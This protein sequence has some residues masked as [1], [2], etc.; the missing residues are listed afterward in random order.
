M[1]GA[2]GG[3]QRWGPKRLVVGRAR[4]I[5]LAP[6]P[7][8]TNR[9]LGTTALSSADSA[10]VIVVA[11]DGRSDVGCWGGLLTIEASRRGVAGVVVHGALRDVDEV[12]RLVV[13][14][15]ARDATPRSARGRIHE[16]ATDVPVTIDGLHVEPG[17]W[18]VADGSGVVF[19]SAQE[20]GRVVALAEE[21]VEEERLMCKALRDGAP[22]FQVLGERYERLLDATDRE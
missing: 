21:I 12:N 6:G 17:A 9:H 13:P 7:G 4:T 22:G 14:V 16:V 2:V 11:S 18:V 5:A 1:T 20:A 10:H 3:F 8:T 15:F 19:F